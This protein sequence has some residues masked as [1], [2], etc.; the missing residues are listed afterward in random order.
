MKRYLSL[1]A[2][3]LLLA[4]CTAP[5]T[6]EETPPPSPP[7]LSE[8]VTVSSPVPEKKP[9]PQLPPDPRQETID[10]LMSSMTLE[11]KAGQVF[12]ARC[13]A[14]NGAALAADYHLGGYILFGRDFKDAAGNWLTEK[15]LTQ[16]IQSY[17]EASSIPL[18]IGVDEE[19]GTVARASRNPNL[20]PEKCRSPQWL[21]EHD[22]GA[23]DIF[24]EDAWEKCNT[25]YRFGINVN[26]APVCDVSTNPKSF[27]YNRTLGQDAAATAEYVESVVRAM[28][29]CPMGSVLKHFPGYGDNADTHTGSALDQRPLENFREQDFLPFQAGI[30]A[31]GGTTAVLVSHNIVNAMDP[32]RPASLSPAVYQILREELNFQGA[33]LTDDLEMKAAAQYAKTQG[34]SSAV[35][36]LA[37]GC[38]M[39]LTGDFQAQ[40]PQVLTALETGSLTQ[41]RLDEAA[42]RVL[43]WK[44]DLGLIS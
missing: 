25:L 12:F 2:A 1:L 14:R 38:D 31:G 13:P 34:Q 27:I 15:Q 4:G 37:A 44:Y 6:L 3:L 28:S 8:G 23:D 21:K 35:L 36:A 26:L 42:A 41:E 39:V 40:I 22:T 17:Q 32:D 7:P 30:Q 24:A 11:E 16:T 18:L 19:G 9:E 29:V 33:A 20:F 5:S 10:A 43:G